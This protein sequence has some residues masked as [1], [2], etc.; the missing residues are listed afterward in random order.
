MAFYHDFLY[1]DTIETPALPTKS[2]AQP[3]RACNNRPVIYYNNAD[4]TFYDKPQQEKRRTTIKQSMFGHITHK[5]FNKPLQKKTEQHES[6]QI[7]DAEGSTNAVYLDDGKRTWVSPLQYPTFERRLM[8]A[9]RKR[10]K[11]DNQTDAHIAAKN[12]IKAICKQQQ[13]KHAKTI[14]VFKVKEITQTTMGRQNASCTTTWVE[15]FI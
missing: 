5:I 7:I 1:G 6:V 13:I 15:K 12:K 10:A 14:T 8:E 2:R 3:P 9:A 11:I 4:K